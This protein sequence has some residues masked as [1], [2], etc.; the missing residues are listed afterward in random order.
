M[1]STN[2]DPREYKE[3]DY[4]GGGDSAYVNKRDCKYDDRMTTKHSGPVDD[5]SSG[6]YAP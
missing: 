2:N 5:Y 3:R 4:N 6:Y 1:S